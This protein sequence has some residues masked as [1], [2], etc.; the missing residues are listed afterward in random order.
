VAVDLG[1]VRHDAHRGLLRELAAEIAAD[2]DAVAWMVYGSVAPGDAHPG[3]DVDVCV[4]LA[5]GCR[6]PFAAEV[7]RGILVE[8]KY[9]DAAAARERLAERPAEVYVHLDG[10][11]VHDS[12]GG[13]AALRAEAEERFRAYRPPAEALPEM[14]HW[15]HSARVKIAAAVDAGDLLRAAYVAGVT[16]WPILEG[17]WLAGG[18]PMPPA[19]AVWAHLGDLA[20]APPRWWVEALF[21]GE[22]RERSRA[23]IRL[24]DAILIRL[25]PARDGMG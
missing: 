20:D 22:A 16:S 23:A 19:G 18:R 9:V 4:L 5:D 3:S 17:L 12:A 10:R 11:V 7:R 13:L 25:D 24:I 21:L 8:R 1:F 15:L 6:R 2:V 14:A